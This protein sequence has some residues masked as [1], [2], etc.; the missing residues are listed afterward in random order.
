MKGH[1]VFPVH[2][3]NAIKLLTKWRLGFS[4]L[5]DHKLRNLKY[6]KPTKIYWINNSSPL[7]LPVIHTSG[8]NIKTR[9]LRSIKQAFLIAF[10]YESDYFKFKKINKSLK[11]T[12]AFLTCW[13][14]FEN[15]LFFF[16]VFSKILMHWVIYDFC[17]I[18]VFNLY[19]SYRRPVSCT[20][21]RK[22][23]LSLFMFFS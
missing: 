17:T 5:N 11:L 9:L 16:W 19:W 12:V 10:W 15:S 3:I 18:F 4:N 2:D 20:L 6:K 13:K 8:N 22:Y 1:S 21:L 23:L 14:H 7:V